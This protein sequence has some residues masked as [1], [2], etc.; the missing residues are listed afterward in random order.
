MLFMYEIMKG[1]ISDVIT[2]LNDSFHSIQKTTVKLGNMG[3]YMV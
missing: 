2:L 1:I 3:L